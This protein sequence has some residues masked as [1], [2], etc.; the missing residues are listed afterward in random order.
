MK[1][2]ERGQCKT[3]AIGN[4]VVWAQFDKKKK[5]KHHTKSGILNIVPCH[6]FY[7]GTYIPVPLSFLNE[8]W[9][10]QLKKR[11]RR[12]GTTN[13]SGGLQANVFGKICFSSNLK[14]LPLMWP[15]RT[16]FPV[17]HTFVNFS[18]ERRCMK[19]PIFCPFKHL[20]VKQQILI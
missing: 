9:T 19:K 17:Y 4:V 6:V 10:E 14:C 13:G 20:L 11:C 2:Y 7:F 18:D 16:I 12:F 8:I 15:R 1:P 5:K 3:C